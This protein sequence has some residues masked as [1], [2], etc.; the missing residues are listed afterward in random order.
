MSKKGLKNILLNI[1]TPNFQTQNMNKTEITLSKVKPQDLEVLLTFAKDVFIE[2]FGGL[3]TKENMDEYTQQAFTKQQ[4]NSEIS[5]P[6]STFYF[7]SHNGQKIGYLKVNTA[8]AQTEQIGEHALEIERIYVVKKYYGQGVGK[9][10]FQKALN[11]GKQLNVDCIWLGVWE[12]NRRAIRFYEKNGFTAFDKH[13]FMLGD[14]EQTDIM[15]K[16]NL[17]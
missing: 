10:L 17:T 4:L 16:L 7:A 13:F 5:N 15:M 9:L 6:N 3:N 8:E 12:E 1:S 2:A 11:I 14:D